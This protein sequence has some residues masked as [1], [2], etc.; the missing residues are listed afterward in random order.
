MCNLYS[1]RLMRR[2][3][4]VSF[5]TLAWVGFLAW[6]VPLG[7]F[8]FMGGILPF[9]A[10]TPFSAVTCSASAFSVS[11]P[12]AVVLAC[13]LG[14]GCGA[15]TC[16]LVALPVVVAA[17][18]LV[19]AA[20]VLASR[21]GATSCGAAGLGVG[22]AP[23]TCSS[24]AFPVL[25]T[26]AVVFAPRLDGT[27]GR[28]PRS[29]LSELGGGQA[30]S[31]VKSI[32]VEFPIEKGLWQK[33]HVAPLRDNGLRS[34]VSVSIVVQLEQTSSTLNCGNCGFFAF[35]FRGR[36]ATSLCVLMR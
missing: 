10:V 22:C 7:R 27:G 19:T 30:L 32:P 35:L 5:C 16:S 31:C 21:L 18:V 11:V 14:V 4:C 36:I 6:S 8:R 24:D 3:C 15:G 26:A 1:N 12:A 2:S 23:G 34:L 17:A 20:V 9:V 13:R 33:G 25:V 28:A 29:E